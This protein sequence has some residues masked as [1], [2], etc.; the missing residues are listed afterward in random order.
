MSIIDLNLVK[1]IL[2][3]I[4]KWLIYSFTNSFESL[5]VSSNIAPLNY[6]SCEDRVQTKIVLYSVPDSIDRRE[7]VRNGK[8]G[9]DSRVVMLIPL[10]LGSVVNYSAVAG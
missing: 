2:L 5:D 1:Y 8:N 3:Q 7:R 4:S 6:L 9:S 10:S